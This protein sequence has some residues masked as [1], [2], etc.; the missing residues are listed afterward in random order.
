MTWQTKKLQ[1]TRDDHP[2]ERFEPGTC[3][4]CETRNDPQYTFCRNCV[5]RLPV[6]R[7]RY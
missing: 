4:H 6:S 1:E 5:E 7:D 3:P 2:W